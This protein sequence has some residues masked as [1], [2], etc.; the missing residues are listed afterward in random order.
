MTVDTV[1]SADNDRPRCVRNAYLH[2]GVSSTDLIIL[3]VS[4]LLA[5]LSYRCARKITIIMTSEKQI[6]IGTTVVKD[7][8]SHECHSSRFINDIN[9]VRVCSAR[10]DAD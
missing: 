8:N 1:L 10:I 9:S 6:F 2:Y 3:T 4:Y 5:F 7:I